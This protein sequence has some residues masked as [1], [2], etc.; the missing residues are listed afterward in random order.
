MPKKSN[1]IYG[2]VDADLLAKGTRH[3]NIVYSAGLERFRTFGEWEIELC[4][5]DP[6]SKKRKD[7]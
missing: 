3:P 1:H 6:I 7:S 2:L 5:T 4:G